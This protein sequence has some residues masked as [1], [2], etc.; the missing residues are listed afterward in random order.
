MSL[1][2]RVI[3]IRAEDSPNVQIALA[4]IAKGLQPSHRILVPG[5]LSYRDYVLRRATWDPIKQAI[6]LDAE[7]WEG[8][9][10][11]L[12]PTEWLSQ[13][14]LRARL[15]GTTHR[16]GKAMGID[17]GEGDAD[18]CWAIVDESGLIELVSKRTYDTSVIVG[19]TL[20]LMRR[21]HVP[22]ERVMFDR[23][24]GG[25]QH[26]DRMRAMG[27]QVRTVAFGESVTPMPKMGMKGFKERTGEREE[28]T[29]YKNRRAE[30]FWA[31]RMMCDPSA[32]EPFAIPAKYTEL[33]RQLSLL[34]LKY[35]KE[36]QFYLPSKNKRSAESKEVTLT[37]LLGRSPDQADALVVALHSMRT[38]PIRNVAGAV[39]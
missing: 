25:K 7:F 20:A 39:G 2:R 30:M 37:E 27:F 10:V 29:I 36:G 11:R 34:P 22:A 15:L 35:D 5:V 17:P 19:D 32:G 23:G 6:G 4:E 12:L 26:A 3:K 1:F 14:M 18:T 16:A 13:C 24:G 8:A 33:L 31:L 21:F 28:R 38:R 9:D